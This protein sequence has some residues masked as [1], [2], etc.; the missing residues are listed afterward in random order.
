MESCARENKPLLIIADDVDGEALKALVMNHVRGILKLC[1]IRSPEFGNARSDM[2]SDLSI[3]FGTKVYT[4]VDDMP[5][6]LEKLGT[7]KKVVVSR[8]DSIFMTKFDKTEEVQRRV[9]AIKEMMADP[10][11]S[12]EEID[13][14]KRRLANLSGAVAVLR[15]GGATETELQERKDRVEDALH[16]TQAAI[17]EGIL[18]GGGLAL[19]R[20]SSN[21]SPDKSWDNDFYVGYKM[22]LDSAKYPIVNIVKNCGESSEL[23]LH[24]LSNMKNFDGYDARNKKYGNLLD[25]GVIDPTKVVRCALENSI[26]VANSLLSVGCSIVEDEEK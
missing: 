7:V 24:N 19:F 15:V 2:M 21:V 11:N 9:T 20:A 23:V 1:V 18:P 8:Y 4:S 26:S 25:L 6:Q 5:T 14:L 10:E 3:L 12:S 22:V 17:E 13:S 16:A